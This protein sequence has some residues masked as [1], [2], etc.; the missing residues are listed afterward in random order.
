MLTF[1]LDSN[2]DKSLYEQLYS[3]IKKSIEEGYLK[4][5]EKLP[6]KRKLA[7]MIEKKSG[8]NERFL[9]DIQVY[10]AFSFVTTSY[11]DADRIIKAFKSMK[12]GRRP[13]IE[14]AK[15]EKKRSRR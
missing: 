15:T 6:S 4:K 5:N 11:N 3:E 8:V 12:R 2:S 7:E 9:R 1:F 14:L 10:D 13:M